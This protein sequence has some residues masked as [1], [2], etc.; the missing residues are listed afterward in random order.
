M[1]DIN[2]LAAKNLFSA[3]LID[4]VF[5][6]CLLIGH[7]DV[8]S[9]FEYIG[10]AIGWVSICLGL[11][12]LIALPAHAHFYP[13]DMMDNPVTVLRSV[14][15]D[16]YWITQHT[17]SAITAAVAAWTGHIALA[18]LIGLI[19]FMLPIAQDRALAEMGVPPR[20]G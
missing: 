17:L 10:V 6:G 7:Y 11:F 2:K 14:G 15:P 1:I 5:V 9:E 12:L 19:A 4:I 18:V 16:W 13:S 20:H 8:V 3:I